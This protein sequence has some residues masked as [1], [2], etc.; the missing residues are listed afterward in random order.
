MSVIANWARLSQAE[1]D[2]AYNNSAAVADSPTLNA[3]REA[4]SKVFRAANP[5]HLDLRYAARERNTWDLF[6][7]ADPDAPCIV[8]IHG[9]YWQRN[10]KDQFADLIAGPHARGWAAAL[11]GYT[12]APEASLTEIVAEINAALDWLAAHGPPH[13]ISGPIVLSGWSAGGHLTAACLDHPLV[14]AGL[15]ISGIFELGP[16]RDTYLNEKLRLTETE[17]IALSPM[18]GKPVAKPLAFAYGTAELPP[19]VSDSRDLHALRAAAH[20]PGALIPVPRANHFTI[21]HELRDADGLLTRH[22][23]ALLSEG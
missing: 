11:P 21:V 14:R 23:A 13:G 5:R 8:F 17:I 22:L 18:R 9:G 10:S 16:V 20:L 15:A 3:A 12:L 4:A 2:A 19:L 1:R 7:V 6:P